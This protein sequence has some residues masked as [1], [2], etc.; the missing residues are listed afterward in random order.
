MSVVMSIL[1]YFKCVPVKPESASDE[2]ADELPE[3]NSS[4][5]KSVPASYSYR[6]SEC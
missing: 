1:Q 5:S 2:Q 6:I 3:P 4:L